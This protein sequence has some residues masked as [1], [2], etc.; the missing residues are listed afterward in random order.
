MPKDK[1]LTVR[2]DSEQLERLKRALGV[3]ESKT[4]RACLNCTENV[5]QNFFG[6]EVVDI[7]RRDPKDENRELFENR[8]KPAKTVIQKPIQ[9]SEPGSKVP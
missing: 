4:I 8:P 6:G 3:D 2:V 1:L 7:F 5:I 9:D